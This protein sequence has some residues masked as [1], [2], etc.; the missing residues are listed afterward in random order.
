MRI[1]YFLLLVSPIWGQSLQVMSFNI[2]YPNPND[3]THIWAVRKNLVVSTIR[4]HEADL[5][6]LQ[7]AFRSQLDDLKKALPGYDWVGVCRTDGSQEPNPDNEFSAILYN[8]NRLTLTE[9]GTFW[10]SENPEMA[11]S[12]GW[13]AALPRIVTWGLFEEK[14]SG[15]KFYHINTHFDHIGEKARIESAKLLVE[16][17]HKM[18]G[19]LPVV[20]TGDFNANPETEI[21]RIINQDFK[22]GF[23]TT[24]I[25]HH[26]PIATF[27]NFIFPGIPG[28]RIDYV[29]VGKGFRVKKH[30]ILS[31]VWSGIFPSDHFPVLATLYFH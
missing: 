6:G 8:T 21:Y 7:E 1:L 15:K 10:L 16:K 2:R 22:D 5:I 27:T 23:L 26:G 3:G 30:A 17:A 29:F 31:E 13:D 19:E 28:T 9:S 4:Y 14:E 20:I 11:G 24:E 25:P 12:K 18:I